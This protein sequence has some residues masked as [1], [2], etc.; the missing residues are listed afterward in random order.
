MF[1][2]IVQRANGL[3]M[4]LYTRLSTLVKEQLLPSVN[5]LRVSIFLAYQ[6]VVNLWFR[7]VQTMLN[8]KAWRAQ[9]TIAAQSIKA[10]LTIAKAKVIQIGQPQATTVL[11]TN[12]PVVTAQLRKRGKRVG[13]T[14]SAQSRL[15][16][17]RIAQTLMEAQLT[18]DGLKSPEAVNQLLQRAKRQQKRGN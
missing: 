1:T 6:S 7:L 10:V 5:R 9:L 4:G 13:S 16:A 12:Q 2:H 3:L 15:N 18:V 8:I 11:S 17:S 14:K